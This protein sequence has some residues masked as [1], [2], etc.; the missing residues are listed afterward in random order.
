MG[1]GIFVGLPDAAFYA[2]PRNGRRCGKP[3]RVPY[4][5]RLSNRLNAP[6]PERQAR[7]RARSVAETFQKSEAK[8]VLICHSM[9]GLAARYFLEV[10][11]GRELTSKLITIGTPYRGI[12]ALDTL[13]IGL[14]LEVGPVGLSVD[15]L[16]RS[17][18]SVYQLLPTYKCLDVGNGKLRELSGGDFAATQEGRCCG[19][20]RL[21]RQDQC[22][23]RAKAEVPALGVPR[24]S[25]SRR[26]NAR[27][28]RTDRCIP[29]DDSPAP[30]LSMRLP[31]IIEPP[32][33]TCPRRVGLPALS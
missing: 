23:H 8:L 32:H 13:A 11:G 24:A 31:D 10:L 21:S 6:A 26:A 22:R 25:I 2:H 19:G 3:R 17:F 18:P 15:K 27:C 4:D 16:V 7:P 1:Y 30:G 28:S 5:W 20:T 9:D 33:G 14:T 12:D 29:L